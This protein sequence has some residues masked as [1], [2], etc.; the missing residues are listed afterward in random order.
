VIELR[1]ATSADLDGVLVFWAESAEDAHRPADTRL[2]I[3]R[4]IARDP[5]ALT[6]AVD[7]GEVI[8]SLISGWDGWRFHLYRLAVHPRRRREGIAHELLE[9]AEERL[10]ALGA[11]RIDAMVLGDNTDAHNFWRAHGYSPQAEW[12]RW[13]KAVSAALEDAQ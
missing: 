5:D 13:I 4:L 1:A 8:G 3:E 10:V 6:I 12:N 7:G 2:A 11:V 9:R